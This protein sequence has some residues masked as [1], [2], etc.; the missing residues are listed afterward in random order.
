MGIMVKDAG[1]EIHGFISGSFSAF[2]VFVHN[3]VGP[4]LKFIFSI[5]RDEYRRKFVMV[6][7]KKYYLRDDAGK[8]QD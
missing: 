7:G 1:Y 5:E 4:F 2:S 8:I 3:V 6:F